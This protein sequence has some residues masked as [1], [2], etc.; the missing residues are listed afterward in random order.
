MT[1]EEMNKMTLDLI[2]DWAAD[3][4][5]IAGL[6]NYLKPEDNLEK[7]TKLDDLEQSK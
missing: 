3:N 4:P 6:V 1:N 5:F 2:N 7:I